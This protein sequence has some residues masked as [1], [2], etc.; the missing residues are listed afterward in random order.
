MSTPARPD[1]RFASFA[2]MR[3]DVDHLRRVGYERAGQWELAT[4]LDHLAK[5]LSGPFREG[6]RNLPWPVGPIARRLVHRMV[7]RDHYPSVTIPMMP[8]IRPDPAA[9]I[10]D[11]YPFFLGACAE[12]ERL[13]GDAV[14]LPPFGTMPRSDFVGM[15]LL[16]GAH[17]LSYLKPKDEKGI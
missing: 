12:C 11:A 2:A 9:T 15:Q 5:T 10:D 14:T 8:S 7:E 6:E 13:A 17:H 16:H 1:L 4:M 3:A